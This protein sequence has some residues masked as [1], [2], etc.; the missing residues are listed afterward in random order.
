MG[1]LSEG[2]GLAIPASIHHVIKPSDWNMF[3]HSMGF[4][5][6]VFIYE[7][8]DKGRSTTF[9]GGDWTLQAG[10]PDTTC[11]DLT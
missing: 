1:F 3:V 6:T 5:D 7:L 9:G 10:L 8:A 11:R 2:I 4:L